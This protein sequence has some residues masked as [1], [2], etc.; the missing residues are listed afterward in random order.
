MTHS[1]TVWRDVPT[2]AVVAAAARSGLAEQV[3]CGPGRRPRH[4]RRQRS[5]SRCQRQGSGVERAGVVRPVARSSAN[6]AVP[7]KSRPPPRPRARRRT[8]DAAHGSLQPG[9]GEGTDVIARVSP[10]R[11]HADDGDALPTFGVRSARGAHRR[12]ECLPHRHQRC[13]P[14]HTPR[15]AV[16]RSC[17]E[18]GRSSGASCGVGTGSRGVPVGAVRAGR[19]VPAGHAG[20]A[21]RSR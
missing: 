8:G 16:P 12:R 2:Y 10:R 17:K 13:R 5:E 4:A 21:G 11:Q 19:T 20:R 7:T 15:R 3:R 9:S 6:G 14:T 1:L 18:R